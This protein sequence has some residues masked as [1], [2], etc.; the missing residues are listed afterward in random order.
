MNIPLAI[1]WDVNG[2]NNSQECVHTTIKLDS[3]YR[4]GVLN[5]AVWIGLRSERIALSTS[6]K[7]SSALAVTALLIARSVLFS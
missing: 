1:I 2:K 4:Q 3:Q 6:I 5:T 7:N